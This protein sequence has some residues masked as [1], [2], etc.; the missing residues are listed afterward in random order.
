[1]FLKVPAFLFSS[2]L[3]FFFFTLSVFPTS[4]FAVNL[5]WVLSSSSSSTAPFPFG[6]PTSENELAL[7]EYTPKTTSFSPGPPA[8]GDYLFTFHFF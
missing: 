2:L 7:V 6:S 1:M 4:D 8:E 5:S 3:P